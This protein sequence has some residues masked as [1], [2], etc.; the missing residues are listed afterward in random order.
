MLADPNGEFVKALGLAHES[1]L[2]GGVRSKRFTMEVDDN[3]VKHLSVDLEF[4][5]MINAAPNKK[6]LN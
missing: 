1:P 6:F 5:G 4:T 3:V 2:L